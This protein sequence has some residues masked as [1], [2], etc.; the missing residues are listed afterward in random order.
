MLQKNW[1][2][3]I[4]IS[5][6][7]GFVTPGLMIHYGM[8]KTA[9]LAISRGLAEMTRGTKVTVNS[10]RSGPTRSEGIVDFLKSL[11]SDPGAPTER[12]ESEFFANGRPSSPLQ[13]LIEPEEIAN[14]VAY[15]A[16][17]L[18]SATNGAALRVDGGVIPTI[19]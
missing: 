11:A 19:G 7:S 17:P 14:L 2:R 3:T 18:S 15:V 9:Q 12:I 16:S 5:S 4:F 1:G 13:R 8:T 6:E 10:V